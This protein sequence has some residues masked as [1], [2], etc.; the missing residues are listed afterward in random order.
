MHKYTLIDYITSEDEIRQR[1]FKQQKI[2]AQNYEAVML[3]KQRQKQLEKQSAMEYIKMHNQEVKVEDQ[4]YKDY[5]NTKRKAIR[6]ILD[7][8]K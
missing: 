7:S 3:E 6:E 4:R 5:Y 2:L 1:K 8:N